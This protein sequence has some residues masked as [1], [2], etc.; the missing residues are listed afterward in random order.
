VQKLVTFDVRILPAA[1][2]AMNGFDHPGR[3]AVALAM[4]YVIASEGLWNKKFIE[5]QTN[6]SP[7]K[8]LRQL[9]ATP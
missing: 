3:G 9:S 5:Q 8:L 1:G 2:K 6:T 4:A 7:S